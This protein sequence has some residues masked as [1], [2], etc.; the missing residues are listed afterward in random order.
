MSK[1]FYKTISPAAVVAEDQKAGGARLSWSGDQQGL[2]RMDKHARL[3]HLLDLLGTQRGHL[4]H[5]TQHEAK[6]AAHHASK[7]RDRALLHAKKAL[8][9]ADKV[10]RGL[11]RAVRNER[12]QHSPGH[13]VTA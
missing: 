5:L 7:E 3:D 2:T 10:V 1:D 13:V 11:E 8:R 12:K 9:R 6:I 4:E